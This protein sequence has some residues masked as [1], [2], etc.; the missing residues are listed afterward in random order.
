MA[1]IAKSIRVEQKV[2][3]YIEAYQ[4]EGFNEKFENIIIFAMETEKKTLARLKS[5]EDDI[6][7]NKK[8][9][10]KLS[11]EILKQRVVV[12]RL[13]NIFRICDEMDRQIKNYF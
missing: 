12:S 5:I 3:D 4:G 1:K 10:S 2:F 11:D 7:V 6:I 8:T 9:S 13:D